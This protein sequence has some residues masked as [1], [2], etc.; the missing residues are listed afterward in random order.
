[1]GYSLDLHW[2]MWEKLAAILPSRARFQAFKLQ[3]KQHVELVVAAMLVISVL[4]F[5]YYDAR[6]TAS[7]VNEPQIND[8]FFVDY[9]ALDP[10]SNY[11]FRYIPMRIMDITS[12]GIVFKVGNIAHSTPV[13]ARQHFQFDKALTLRNFYRVDTAFLSFDEIN[14]LYEDGSIYGARRPNTIYIDGWMVIY[15]HEIHVSE[16]IS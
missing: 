5:S 14:A 2:A 16:D 4:A 11:H 12:K 15:K 8:F 9:F 10:S 1:M 6:R 13:S 3:L 7:I